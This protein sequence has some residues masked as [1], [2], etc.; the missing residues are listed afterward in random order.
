MKSVPLISV[1]VPIYKTEAYL[2][3]CLDSIAKQTLVEFEVICVDDCS[4]DNSVEIVQKFMEHDTR[5]NLIK[6]QKNSGQGAARNEGVINAKSDY[7]FFVDSD[8]SL[9]PDAL[10]VAWNEIKK[11]EVDV[12]VFGYQMVNSKGFK[13][14]DYTPVPAI[15]DSTK[16]FVNIFSVSKPAPWNKLWKKSLFVDNDIFFPAGIFY[17]DLATTP[18]LMSKAKRI[19]IISNH[20][21]F[22]LGREDSVTF[23]TS[24]KHIIDYLKVFD[25]LYDFLMREGLMPRYKLAFFWAF[26]RAIGYHGFNASEGQ[27]IDKEK[28]QYLRH[29]LFAKIGFLECYDNIKTKSTDELLAHLTYSR[30]VHDVVTYKPIWRLKILFRRSVFRLI[31]ILKSNSSKYFYRFKG[32][33]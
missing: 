3:T 25:I 27:M 6:L 2:K 30:T 24:S 32:S 29:L 21:Y 8:D 26:E 1:I 9:P 14:S 28:K 33:V 23:T 12:L 31:K 16:D 22:Y 11:G 17:Q 10:S 5:F 19:K 18:R 15:Y 13:I 7:I 20:L 4:P